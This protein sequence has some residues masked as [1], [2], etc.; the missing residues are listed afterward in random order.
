M[1][2]NS[3]KS[4]TFD[5]IK[6]SQPIGEFYIGTMK[7]KD[8]CEITKY[9]FRRLVTEE[10]FDSYLGIQRKVNPQRVREIAKYVGTADACFPT[11]VLLA[12]PGVCAEYN[13]DR[14]S[15]QLEEYREDEDENNWVPYDKIATVLDGQHRIAGLQNG[16]YRGDF[17][18]NVSV[19][20]DIDVADQAY[21]F[22]TVN[23]AQTKVNKS[24]V[25]DLFD[26]AKKRSPQKTCHNIAVALDKNERSPFFKKIMRL[27]V[28]TEGRFNETITQAT[29][30]QSLLNYISADPV[31]DR[32]AYLTDSKPKLDGLEILKKY[33]FRNMFIEEKDLEITD[34]IWN[35]FDAVKKKWPTAWDSTGKG[36]MLNKTN[37]FKALMRFLRPAYLN[38]TAPGGVPS[39]DSFYTIFNRVDMKDE[40]FNTTDFKPGSSGE[41]KL[42]SVLREQSRV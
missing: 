6:V 28:S 29:F 35:Y 8:L 15:L 12:V 37:G 9:D 2:E 11:A 7:A 19:F 25:Y 32:N 42:V 20:V 40:D 5:C 27:G 41:G 14:K 18:I 30:V 3:S 33:L 4:L 39:T 22:S 1:A 31:S 21:I 36:L 26:L 23:L 17:E 13:E 38:L 10:G 16:Q 24:L 34:I